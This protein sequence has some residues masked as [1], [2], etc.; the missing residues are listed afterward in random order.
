MLCQSTGFLSTFLHPSTT[1][2]STF[3]PKCS[4]RARAFCPPFSTQAPIFCPPFSP[5]QPARLRASH[6]SDTT[7]TQPSHNQYME[8]VWK[9]YGNYMEPIWKHTHHAPPQTPSTSNFSRI[10]HPN[11]HHLTSHFA[12]IGCKD[13]KKIPHLQIKIST[14]NPS[15]SYSPPTTLKQKK[16]QKNFHHSKIIP[17]FATIILKR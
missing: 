4:A 7:Q 6:N 9:L 11:T 17:I 2:L 10:T 3:L 14:P 16:S 12:T 1:F 15:P 8:P 13:T 5:N